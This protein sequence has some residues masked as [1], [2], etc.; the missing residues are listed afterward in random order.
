MK[1]ETKDHI[2]SIAG[3]NSTNSYEKYLG[4][5]PLVGRS[6]MSTFIGIQGKIWERINGWKEKFLS[7]A[8]KEVMI[9]VVIQVIPTY[10]MSVFQLPKT[11]CKEITSMMFRF[12]WGTR[13][14]RAGL[15]G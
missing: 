8:G 13:R 6:R 4:L 3:V 9:K 10:T 7:Q 1:Q 15:H 5:P 2:L 11:L 12:W 14:M